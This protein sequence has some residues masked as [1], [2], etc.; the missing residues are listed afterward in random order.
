MDGGAGLGSAS[1]CLELYGRSVSV[2]AGAVLGS[3]CQSSGGAVT[4]KVRLVQ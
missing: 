4:Y 1:G 3:S 2:T